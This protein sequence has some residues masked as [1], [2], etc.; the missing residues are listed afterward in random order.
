M[1]AALTIS[2]KLS[3]LAMFLPPLPMV[4]D[5][6]ILLLLNFVILISPL[7]ALVSSSMYVFF[8]ISL[9]KPQIPPRKTNKQLCT[10]SA[11]TS[12]SPSLPTSLTLKYRGNVTCHP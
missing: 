6:C 1:P 4:F 12:T 5:T 10:A 2:V 7:R 11:S 9:P 3:L 8:E